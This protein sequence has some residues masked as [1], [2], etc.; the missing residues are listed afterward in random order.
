MAVNIKNMISSMS[1]A[2]STVPPGWM[3]DAMTDSYINGKGLRVTQLDIVDHG[4]LVKAIT[5]IF[6]TTALQNVQGATSGSNQMA[7]APGANGPAGPSSAKMTHGPQPSNPAVGDLWADNAG[8]IYIYTQNGWKST[9]VPSGGQTFNASIMPYDPNS[10]NSGSISNGNLTVGKNQSY[11]FHKPPTN[12]I[13]IETKLGRISV[14]TETGDITVPVGVGRDDAIR[15]FWFGFQKHFQ[16]SNNTKYEE[17]IKYLKRDLAATKAS[18]VLMKKEGEKD[19]NKRVAEK[20][21]KKYGNEK[22]IMVKPED[23]I[24]FI[25]EG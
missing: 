24:R 3:Y 10:I 17:E 19:A 23:L 5:A 20:V 4:S 6:G 25:E 8:D 14:D 11:A 15:E 2:A 16:P 9:A 22:F 18:A 7:S 1:G 12:V 13:S 21:R